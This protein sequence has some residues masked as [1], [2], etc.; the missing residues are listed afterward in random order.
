MEDLEILS[1]FLKSNINIHPLAL[2]ELKKNENVNALVDRIISE[3]QKAEKK[4]EVITPDFLEFLRLRKSIAEPITPQIV[5]ERPRKRFLAEEYEAEIKLKKDITKKSFSNGNIE[6]FVEYFNDR[7]ERLAKILRSRNHLRDA[8]TI[9]WIKNASFRGSVQVIGIVSGVR[10]SQKGH[11]ILEIEDPTGVIP[12]LILNS[13]RELLE[14]SREIVKDEVIGIEGNLGKSSD[15]IIA[16]E[17]F[18]PDVPNNKEQNKSEV[19]LALAI[20]SDTHVGS[21]KFLEGEFLKFL[22]WLNGEIGSAKQVQ[23]AERVKYLI[24]G[25][26][27]VDGVGIYP[28][29]EGELLIKDIHAQYE[30]FAEFLSM[31]PQHIEIIILPGNH[32]ATRQAE[33]QPAISEEFAGRLYSDARV[34]MVG[35]P[36]W[37]TLHGV[38]VLSYHGRSLDDVVSNIPGMSYSQPD[39]AMLALL[40]KRHLTPIYGDKV[41]LAPELYAYR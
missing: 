7:Y 12:V 37:A 29:Q 6:S 35:N 10:K 40:K 8:A 34:H 5:V 21:T 4:P 36:C 41:L 39:K 11:V 38:D 32:D 26:D 1:K 9:E 30:K 18:F 33:P 25:G 31:V 23:L 13:N 16:S 22:R 14:I 19:P 2:Q 20:I 27:L 3:T 17:I 24:V 28:E 15:I